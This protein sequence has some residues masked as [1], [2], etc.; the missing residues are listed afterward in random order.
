MIHG[1]F[2]EI[3]RDPIC[4][5]SSFSEMPDMN[6]TFVSQAKTNCITARDDDEQGIS[7]ARSWTLGVW[8]T[9]LI[10]LYL[11]MHVLS[12]FVFECLIKPIW[13]LT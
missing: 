12:L 10:H 2:M 13:L 4:S 5:Y 9:N 6:E 11:S 1:W 8:D 3:I 7:L